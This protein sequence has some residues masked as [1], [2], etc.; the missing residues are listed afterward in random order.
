MH[1]DRTADSQ[2]IAKARRSRRSVLEGAIYVGAAVSA[3]A[4]TTRPA[5][6]KMMKRA[7]GYQDAPRGNQR[8]AIC[9]QF[10]SP[11]S[12]LI[13]EGVVSPNGWCKIWQSR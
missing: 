3:L 5:A 6:A 12:C 4:M 1:K 2:S 8:C 9:A 11:N 7:A 10:Q 13:V